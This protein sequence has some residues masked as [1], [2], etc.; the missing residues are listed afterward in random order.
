MVRG[1]GVGRGGGDHVSE[2]EDNMQ[3]SMYIILSCAW[4]PNDNTDMHIYGRKFVIMQVPIIVTVI[5]I[6]LN[7][8]MPHAMFIVIACIGGI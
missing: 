4:F 1:L 6:M 8:C 7:Y 3:G 5:N 2:V